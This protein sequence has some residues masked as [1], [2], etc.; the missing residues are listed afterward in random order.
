MGV[1]DPATLKEMEQALVRRILALDGSPY[2]HLHGIDADWHEATVALSV[3]DEAASLSHLAFNVWTESARNTGGER[4]AIRNGY[5]WVDADVRVAFVFQL[6]GPEQV[7]DART[8]SDAAIDIL[9]VLMTDWPAEEPCVNVDIPPGGEWFR[10]AL[11]ADGEW[12]AVTMQFSALL[13]VRLDQ[14]PT[15]VP[16]TS[17]P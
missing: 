7:E 10:T 5:L 3:V 17:T 4:G 15:T 8:A 1:R 12:A 2:T 6:R 16:P 9:R 13:E 14:T 11:T